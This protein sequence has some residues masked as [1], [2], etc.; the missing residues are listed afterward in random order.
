MGSGLPRQ[1]TVTDDRGTAS[2]GGFSGGG[3][4][5]EWRGQFEVRP[6]LAPDTAWVEVLGERIGLPS[7]PSAGVQVRVEPQE[8]TDLA[9]R[10]LWVKLAS[11]TEFDSPDEMETSIEALIAA[12][13][14]ET[15]D[16]AIGEVRKVMGA[17][18][19]GSGTVPATNAALPQPWRSVLAR[20]GRASGPEGLAVAGATTPPLDG[21]TLAILAVRST[22]ERFYADVETVPGLPHSHW[23]FGA[24]DRP[25]LAWWATDDR[26]QH[27]LGAQGEWQFSEDRSGGQIEFWPALDPAAKVLDIMP[28]TMTARAVIRV[29]LRLGGRPMSTPWWRGVPPAVA[30]VSCDGREHQL[31][32]AAGEL[33]APGHPDLESEKI[34]RALAGENYACLDVLEAWEV[35]ADDLRVLVLASRGPAD[36]VAVRPDEPRPTAWTGSTGRAGAARMLRRRVGCD[37]GAGRR[38]PASREREDTLA[39]LLSLGGPMQTRLTATVAAAWR[40]RLRDGTAPAGAATALADTSVPAGT[41]AIEAARPALHAALYGRVVAT[42]RAWTGRPDLRVALTMIGESDRPALA[43]DG[44]GIAVELPFGWISDVWARGLGTCWDRFVLAA[45]PAGDGWALSAVSPDLGP[46]AQITITGPPPG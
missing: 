31:R 19:R 15:D 14:L 12:G 24:V 18:F 43:P 46:P 21:F 9:R 5:D 28:T 26:G 4:D 25:L 35:H 36:P 1:L 13:A 33:R 41:A 8:D 17:L 10:Y 44:D 11:G 7:V 6:P 30:Q 27:Y 39:V 3:S 38:G 32:W 2:T 42:L 22:D 20:R 37:R 34:L 29:P 45:T 23:P 40:E 16:P